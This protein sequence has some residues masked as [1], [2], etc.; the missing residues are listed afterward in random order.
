MEDVT[1][2]RCGASGLLG[3]L[4]CLRFRSS[5]ENQ[6]VPVASVVT[7]TLRLS[8]DDS[9]CGVV[10]NDILRS[11][12]RVAVVVGDVGVCVTAVVTGVVV[13]W[14]SVVV[15]GTWLVPPCEGE[16]GAALATGL[17]HEG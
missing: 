15:A 17:A 13:L 16:V 7:L 1:F 12:R 14:S 10:A 4:C 6:S 3:A 8:V 2:V 5:P 11:K 9:G